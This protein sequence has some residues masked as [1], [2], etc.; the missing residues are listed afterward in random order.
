MCH[1]TFERTRPDQSRIYHDGDH[2][3]D[4]YRHDDILLP[5]RHYYVI[6]LDED[7]RGPRRVHQRHRVR[8][9]VQRLVETHPL[10]RS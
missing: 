4:V 6:H 3:G 1:V 5:G 2:V 7:P 8:E 10:W 9:T